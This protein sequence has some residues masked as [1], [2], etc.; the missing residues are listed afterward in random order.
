MVTN[1]IDLLLFSVK[2]GSSGCVVNSPHTE[3]IKH[4]YRLL[5]THADQRRPIEQ[6]PGNACDERVGNCH[7]L[8]RYDIILSQILRGWDKFSTSLAD[9]LVKYV[10]FHIESPTLIRGKYFVLTSIEG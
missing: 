9:A 3:K 4:L 10:F 8:P 6:F 2:T 1:P 7:W 5:A